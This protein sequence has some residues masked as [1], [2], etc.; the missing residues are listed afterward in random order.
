MI[1]DLLQGV[2]LVAGAIAIVLASMPPRRARWG[3]L[4]GLAAQPL[5]LYSTFNAGQWGMFVLALFYTWG[6]GAGAWRYRRGR[7]LEASL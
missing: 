6:W 7:A 4:V 1:D 5:W 2:M 3:W